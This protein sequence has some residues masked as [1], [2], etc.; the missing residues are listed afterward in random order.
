MYQNH[1]I[2]F[3]RQDIDI[4]AGWMKSKLEKKDLE[5]FGYALGETMVSHSGES[6]KLVAERYGSEF[7]MGFLKGTAVGELE[8]TDLFNCLAAEPEADRIFLT[9]N[10][11][12]GR[13][14]ENHDVNEGLKGLDEMI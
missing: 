11:D 5:G 8:L 10:R 7:A 9:A 12:L 6:P 13:F 4:E 2:Y 1:R 14:F 3:N